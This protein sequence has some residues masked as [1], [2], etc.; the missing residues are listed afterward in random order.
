M[1][2]LDFKFTIGGPTG[3]KTQ[4][5][6][7][8]LLEEASQTL[9]NPNYS[10]K[11][12]YLSAVR[13]RVASDPR[14]QAYGELVKQ[15]DKK[16]QGAAVATGAQEVAQGLGAP[17]A[18][19]EAVQAQG[20]G[21]RT[22][23]PIPQTPGVLGADTGQFQQLS[24]PPESKEAFLGDFAQRQAQ[25]P[26]LAGISGQQ[27]LATPAGG[28]FRSEKEL[29]AEDLKGRR[30]LRLSDTAKEKNEL[31]KA[32][33]QLRYRN[34]DLNL[35]KHRNK[36]TKDRAN[37]L[38]EP[39]KKEMDDSEKE[40]KDLRLKKEKTIADA[41]GLGNMKDVSGLIAAY[42]DEISK[43]EVAQKAADAVSVYV[44]DPTSKTGGMTKDTVNKLF[45]M[46]QKAI[47]DGTFTTV[48]AL[49]QP[50]G[51]SLGSPRPAPAAAPA[52]ATSRFKV[53]EIP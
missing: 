21:P 1:P 31:A 18:V 28:Q 17:Q 46:T 27:A 44:T 42:D 23:S 53:E 38:Y 40:L 39:L 33:L 8:S 50:Q 15:A 3:R 13:R 14:V 32:N 35:A 20:E 48:E 12:F 49:L 6:V 5:A 11:D 26:S 25:D 36:V 34:H 37:A 24:T 51:P 4:R 10:Y 43:A 16:K 19:P 29:A 9:D 30:E 7:Q 47:E 22:S 52:P 41:S 2:A 45:I